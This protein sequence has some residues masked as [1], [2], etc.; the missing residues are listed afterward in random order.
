MRAI[1]IFCEG[2]VLKIIKQI[3]FS[4]FS[5]NGMLLTHWWAVIVDA[6]VIRCIQM[7]VRHDQVQ[8]LHNYYYNKTL[9]NALVFCLSRHQ[10]NYNKATVS[11][12]SVVIARFFSPVPWSTELRLRVEQ[13]TL[14]VKIRLMFQTS[15]LSTIERQEPT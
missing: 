8:S 9:F 15:A 6:T 5:A 4:I 3:H 12:L 7:D 13:L 2:S 10:S 11:H 1:Y 14:N